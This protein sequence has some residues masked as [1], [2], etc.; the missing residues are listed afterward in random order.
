M[1]DY[2]A[3]FDKLL[4]DAGG[5]YT[6]DDIMDCIQQ[7]F[8]QSFATNNSWVITQVHTFPRK[9]VVEIAYILGDK[10]EVTQMQQE[11]EEFARG[12]DA[13]ML[14]ATGRDGW[15][16]IKTSGWRKVSVNYVRTV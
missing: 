6:F 4:E 15:D 16:R 9:K 2:R 10:D 3:E 1:R 5:F 12:I 11:I 8:M 7:G 14:I 13:E